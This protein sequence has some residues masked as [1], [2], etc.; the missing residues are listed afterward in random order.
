MLHTDLCIIGFGI[1]GIA[2]TRWAKESGLRYITLER[3]R[4]AGGVWRSKSY[5]SVMLQTTKHSYAFSD[6]PMGQDVPLHPSDT[7]LVQ[8]FDSYI[9]HHN[10]LDSVQFQC[11][12]VD[13]PQ[14]TGSYHRVLYRNLQTGKLHT[15]HAT[16]L[17]ICSGF[18][19]IPKYS[20][21]VDTREF[22]GDLYHAAD[23]APGGPAR[24]LSMKGRKVLVVGNGPSGCD[25]AIRS[26]KQGADKVE[27]MFRSPR[28]I[29]TRYC[30]CIGLNF[31][32]NRFFLW[33]AM[34]LPL[35]LF[36]S[37]LYLVFY[38]PYYLFGARE[39]LDLPNTIVNR[40][41]LTLNEDFA[42]YLNLRRFRYIQ[43]DRVQLKGTMATYGRVD[44]VPEY[45]T[46]IDTVISATG[47]EIGVPFLGL[48]EIP[49]LYK[50]CMVVN[51]PT[52]GFIG[53][54][55]SFNWIQV[56][57][58]QARWFLGTISGKVTVPPYAEREAAIQRE[59]DRDVPYEYHDLAYLAYVYCDDL[60]G[61]MGIVPKG[62]WWS[63]PRYDT[64]GE[65]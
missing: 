57:D 2:M 35:T 4:H 53:F 49:I 29:F 42:L 10:L 13:I 62:N 52:I 14:K 45:P 46:E 22:T 51:D 58:L 43:A 9:T 5:P 37:L 36:I 8:Y 61:E 63:V 48:N 56:A 23:F 50:R 31:F 11:E 65:D 28:W 6:I 33:M 1:S 44:G 64:Y 24:E 12:V 20:K 55:P 30:G 15:I 41:N 17:A 21:G 39:N 26:V 18:Y 16:Y 32:S 47:Y 59:L 7:D 34:K 40:N 54:A 19:T 25:L 27:L 38:I 60:A 3:E